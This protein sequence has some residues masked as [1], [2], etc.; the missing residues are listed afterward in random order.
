MEDNARSSK[1]L[2]LN[3]E[4]R[5]KSFVSEVNRGSAG[6]RAVEAKNISKG[7]MCIS[8]PRAIADDK[9]I[10]LEVDA[11]NGKKLKAYC[12]VKW[13]RETGADDVDA[14]VSFFC[15]ESE[16]RDILNNLLK[17]NSALN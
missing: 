1:R 15:M 11:G 2:E 8:A 16:K 10:I 12:E 17:T 3:A 13:V 6:F 14:G 5:Y 9:F 4:C 7:G